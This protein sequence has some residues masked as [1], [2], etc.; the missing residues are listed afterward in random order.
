MRAM[1]WRGWGIDL[2]LWVCPLVGVG[3][4]VGVVLAGKVPPPRSNLN[5]SQYFNVPGGARWALLGGAALSP[6]IVA[7]FTRRLLGFLAG[8]CV[9]MLLAAGTG[10]IR[11]HQL[12]DRIYIVRVTGLP[13]QLRQRG[14]VV[15]SAAGGCALEVYRSENQGIVESVRNSQLGGGREEALWFK[16]DGPQQSY[17]SAFGDFMTTPARLQ[18]LGFAMAVNPKREERMDGCDIPFALALP[19]WFLC[20]LAAPLPLVWTLRWRRW[21]RIARRAASGLCIACGYDLRAT[22]EAGGAMLAICPECGAAATETVTSPSSA[23]I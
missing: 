7:L 14:A 19:Y 23:Q 17:P 9:V 10:W 15:V 2:F 18:R 21:R 22:P 5:N 6:L 1:R 20:L 4:F 16:R 8:A 12:T 3:V 11:S 13:P